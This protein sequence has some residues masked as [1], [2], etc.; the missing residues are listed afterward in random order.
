MLGITWEGT[1]HPFADDWLLEERSVIR[2]W[3]NRES[4]SRCLLTG[5]ESH[6]NT[7]VQQ[8]RRKET[9]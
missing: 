8:E 9:A 4:L 1:L 2:R 3:V 7:C 5:K 6:T